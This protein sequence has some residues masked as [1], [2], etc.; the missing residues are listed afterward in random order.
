MFSLA[1][2]VLP[3]LLFLLAEHHQPICEWQ[4]VVASGLLYLYSTKCLAYC[5][6]QVIELVVR[7]Y[8]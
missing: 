7:M 8:E 6:T 4:Y 2:P 5:E 1:P 3:P